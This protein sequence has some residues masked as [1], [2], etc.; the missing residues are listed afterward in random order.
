MATSPRV[1]EHNVD[2]LFISRWSPRAFL[3]KPVP[4]A[5]LMA[6]FEAA[7]WAPSCFNDQ[8]WLFLYTQKETDRELF[9]SLLMDSNQVWASRAPVLMFAL[10]R[11]HFSHNQAPNRLAAFDTGAAWMSLAMAA[12][13]RGLATHAMGGFHQEAA[14]EKLQV[15]REQ[16]EI[17]CAIALGYQAPAASLPENLREREKPSQRKATRVIAAAGSFPKELIYLES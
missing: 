2:E 5:D 14:Y 4:E 7:R 17:Q 6:L 13:K 1:A 10:T 8:P 16:F 3:D 15:P 12:H 11:K 9:L